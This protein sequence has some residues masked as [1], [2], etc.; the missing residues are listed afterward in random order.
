MARKVNRTDVYLKAAQL[1]VDEGKAQK[2]D[3]PF[4]TDGYRAPWKSK[5][6][7]IEFDG[8]QPSAYVDKF[9]LGLKGNQKA[10][11]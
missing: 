8:R 7:G 2:S 10:G 3:F 6:D 5:L 4:G 11:T 1:L 9:T